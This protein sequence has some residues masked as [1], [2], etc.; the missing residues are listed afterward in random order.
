[1]RVLRFLDVCT[2]QTVEGAPTMS[3]PRAVP[4]EG[5]QRT[6]HEH[7]GLGAVR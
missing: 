7:F 5:L 4:D 1:M 2:K 3:N 6:T